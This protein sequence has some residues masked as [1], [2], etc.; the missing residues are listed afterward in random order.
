MTESQTPPLFIQFAGQGVKYMEDLRRMHDSCPPIRSFIADAER[1]I[2]AQAA[3]Y[4][5]SRTGFFCQ[6]L[7]VGS[8]ITKPET[9]PDLGYLLSSPLSHPLIFLT[10]IGTYLSVLAEGVDPARLLALTH[11]ATGF[12]TGVVAAIL[13]S[14]G[15]SFAAVYEGALKAQAMFF[16][17][18]V[19]CQESML[20]FGSRPVLDASLYDS[21]EG[22]PSCMAS[23]NHLMRGKLDQAIAA[24]TKH[25]NVY[26]AYELF[27]GR[28]IVSGL[29]GHLAAFHETLKVREPQAVWRYIPSTIGAHSPFLAH[30]YE[31]S[32]QDARR[33]GL[34]FDGK[35]M[36][37]PVWSNDTGEDLRNVGNII[38]E[39]M[40]AYFLC[41]AI[42]RRQIKPLLPPTSIRYVL[43][44]GPGTGVAS[45]SEN[46]CAG[47][48]IQVVRCAIPLGRKKLLDEVLPSLAG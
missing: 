35:A 48:G 17:Q 18:G 43:D 46:H 23:I 30:A 1:V 38:D 20:G 28:W 24:F 11:S 5:D 37:V 29:P 39:V 3:L 27:P 25:G 13:V 15:R 41:P 32:P 31:A 47:T 10:Q 42:W 26:P 34:S 6:G 22:C 4:D 36:A 14:M 19:R 2:K 16:W 21:V 8:W 12:S 45:L 44:F 7:D 40:R 33:L 9:T